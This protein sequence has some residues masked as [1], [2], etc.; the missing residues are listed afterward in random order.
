MNGII[1]TGDKSLV[2]ETVEPVINVVHII[3]K[4]SINIEIPKVIHAALCILK[5][6]S[7]PNNIASQ[8]ITEILKAPILS[9]IRVFYQI[10]FTFILVRM[11]NI[12]ILVVFVLLA[13]YIYSNYNYP[14][15]VSII[16]TNLDDMKFSILLE[17][18]PVI[19]ENNKTDLEQL[20]NTLFSYM[21]HNIYE[22]DGPEKQND[23][24]EKPEEAEKAEEAE[25]AEEEWHTSRYKYLVLQS[26][27]D[28][29]EI[30]IFPPYIKFDESSP[31]F[32]NDII[33]VQLSIGQCIILPFHWK[34]L[35]KKNNFICLCVHNIATYILP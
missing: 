25:E 18:Q 11:R 1:S 29:S 27:S 22:I 16:Q 24:E 15:H 14:K 13:I 3:N 6:H 34:Y 9:Y 7:I 4:K 31:D 35:I 20:Q 8:T 21:N 10:I 5:N 26:T 23:S 32:E 33:N 28:N 30:Y 2:K 19:I 12:L 17:K